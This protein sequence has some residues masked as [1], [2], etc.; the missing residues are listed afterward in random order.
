MTAPEY[1]LLGAASLVV[2]WLIS[3]A[4]LVPRGRWT[5]ATRGGVIRRV[6]SSGLAW[7]VPLVE[8]L[9]DGADGTDEVALQA[10]ATTRDGVP[11]L[12]L[13]EATVSFPRPMVGT[14]YADP[15]P[16]AERTAEETIARSVAAWSAA[17]LASSAESLAEPLR[18]AVAAA[19]DG[20][21]IIDLSLVEMDVPLHG[22]R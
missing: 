3:G 16:A 15:W 11:V 14:R 20:V 1:V 13:A 19:V 22:P 2:C 18:R 12:V 9:V 17:D 6:R 8:R 10:R 21:E 7:R 5:A 4:R